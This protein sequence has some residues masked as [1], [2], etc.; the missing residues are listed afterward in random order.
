[1]GPIGR[2]RTMGPAVV[3][4]LAFAARVGAAELREPNV[5]VKVEEAPTGGRSSPIFFYAPDLK[6]F[7]VATGAPL[8][9]EHYGVEE[10][11]L[12]TGRWTNA[13]P[14]GA[15]PSYAPESGPTKAPQ[16]PPKGWPN[17]GRKLVDAQGVHRIGFFRSAYSAD[18]RAHFQYAYDPDSKALF[19]YLWNKTLRYDPT[20]RTWTDLKASPSPAEHPGI[21]EGGHSEMIWGS[22]C[23][24]P[25]NKE[26]V[27]CGG[28]AATKGGTPGTWLYSLEKGSW[29][30]VG[31]P[32]DPLSPL[33]KALAGMQDRAWTHVAARRNRFFHTDSDDESIADDQT[34]RLLAAALEALSEGHEIRPPLGSLD[35]ILSP[36]I[37]ALSQA[38]REPRVRQ[39]SG[40]LMEAAHSADEAA[41]RA[42]GE[43][44]DEAIA[45]AAIVFYALDAAAHDLAV[46]PPGRALSQM[47][48]DAS[49]KKIV[50]FGGDGLDR[51]YADT[52]VYDCAT[53]TWE[54]RFPKVSPSPRAGHALVY[55]PKSRKV[56]LLGG[57]GLGDGHSYMY[58]D[59]YRSIPFEM[60]VYDTARNEWALLQHLPLPKRREKAPHTPRGDYRGTWPAAVNDDDVV[61][62]FQGGSKG[63]AT[64]VCRVDPSKIDA[65]GT[66][67]YGVPPG[68]VAF[69]GDED[70]PRKGWRSY[71]PAFYERDVTPEPEKVKAF[72]DNLRPNTWT[73]LTPPKGVD[74]C[75]WGTTAYDP[76]RQQLL[77][78]GGGHS[79][80]KGTNVFHYSVRTNLW[81]S[82]C[83]PDWVL[84]WSGGFL[85]P[86]LLSFRNRPHV[87]VHAYQC[88]AYDPPSGLMVAL[89]GT[90]F[91]YNVQ[92][93][94]W[95]LPSISAPCRGDVMRVALETTPT[96][97]YAWGEVSRGEPSRLFRFEAKRSRWWPLK[98]KGPKLP[99][100]WCDGSGMCYDSTRNCLWLAPGKE[101]FRF[102]KSNGTLTRIATAPPTALGKLALWREQVHVPGAD[103]IL[104]MR[105][106]PGPDGALRNVAYDPAANRWLWLD[107]P[108]VSGGKPHAFRKDRT[109]FSWNAALHYD[110]K[111]GVVLL[112][113][114]VT[115]W[116]LRLDRG[117]ARVEEAR[118]DGPLRE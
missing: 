45:A 5:W 3:L 61:V 117:T 17:K 35:L 76:D 4:A 54:Q 33:R 63:R 64:W 37:K 100:P 67:K 91:L 56:L 57:F 80:Y 87:P 74:V 20:A 8:G 22:L 39:A 104:L 85:C 50:L 86:A 114:P 47:A 92:R 96:G 77:Y 113:N 60:W 95:Y 79:E 48:Y 43:V 81:S 102:D 38:R 82:S 34:A 72:Y 70:S 103:L 73:L 110:A 10:F 18:S 68:T 23:H 88:Y 69:R 16:H 44:D 9:T 14:K 31:F 90:T 42:A 13:Y 55:L 11:D 51:Q 65:E 101:L 28:T 1:M 40:H 98:M 105:L 66:A 59:V 19:A 15:P 58:G 30:R 36:A 24:D 6:R 116:A 27:S 111:L 71:D 53:R 29:R 46:E 84:E 25:V 41:A 78:W 99:G 97:V 109:P 112:H 107:L 32:S 2:M 62:L 89:R 49:A 12:A 26:I 93:R 52:W 83:R 106:F 115:I 7:V 21:L 118:D 94:C 108:F 75:G